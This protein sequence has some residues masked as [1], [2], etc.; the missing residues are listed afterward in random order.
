MNGLV[1]QCVN[2]LYQRIEE[3]W[4]KQ[5]KKKS[6]YRDSG[7]GKYVAT[8]HPLVVSFM[9]LWANAVRLEP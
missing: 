4:S 9:H 8:G 2:A 3:G 5:N 1:F 7:A 6:V